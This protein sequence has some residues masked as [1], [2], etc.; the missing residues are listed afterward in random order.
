MN[1]ARQILKNTVVLTVSD[2]AD[3]TGNAFLALF[4]SRIL[5]ATGLGVYSVALAYY[6]LI[7]RAGAMGASNFLVREIGKDRSRTN[8]YVTHLNAAGTVA[9]VVIMAVFLVVLPYLRYSAELSTSMRVIILAI[10]PGTLKTIQRAVFI[11]HQRVE[12]VT[13]TTLV[14]RILS[15]SAS[16]WLLTHGYG[17]VGLV[18]VFVIEQYLVVICYFY[19]INRF[20][21][22]L[23]WEFEF[24]FALVLIREM[25]TFAALSILAG[26]F[27]QP[28]V[29]LL[30]LVSDEAEVGFYSAALKVVNLCH[31]LPQIAMTNVFPVLSHSYHLADRKFRII[32]EKS[33]K[34][35]LAISLPLTAGTI[36][37]SESIIDLL[38][39]PGFG[40]SVAALQVLAWGIPLSALISV[41]W[42]VLAARN[43]Q[44]LDLRARIITIFAR[45]GSGCLLISPLAS[46]GAAMSTTASLL[47]NALL[48]AR[49]V[50]Q[51]G[52]RLRLLRL[53]WRCALAAVGMGVVA[54]SFSHQL[55][56]WA[57]VPLAAALY[58]LLVLLLKVFSRDDF[59]LFRKLWQPGTAERS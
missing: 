35:L 57:L 22:A 5:H 45:M 17:V 48:L 43:Q 36:A 12:F 4:I 26:L 21:A 3:R 11:A 55:Q 50:N 56:L 15:V 54:W 27:A 46:L 47:L 25:K 40:P 20:I 19:F 9:S 39:G 31:F 32:Q 23:H 2:L 53:G 44:G 28:E 14:S 42:R 18:V 58:V 10:I 34:Y 30:S 37:A 59:A 16:L 1:Q 13:Y 49:Y 6:G 38:Y 24:S 8:R 33:I 41:F 29:I 51:D 7:A 52:T